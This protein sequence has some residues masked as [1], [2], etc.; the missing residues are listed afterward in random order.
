MKT[1]NR[2]KLRRLVEAGKVTAI[3][4]YSFDD[5]HGT[6]RGLDKEMAV[7]MMPD[8]RLKAREGTVHVWDSDFTGRGGSAREAGTDKHGRQVVVLRVH[9]NLNYTFAINDRYV[10]STDE[11]GTKLSNT[12]PAFQKAIADIA[13]LAR[14]DVLD[15]FALWLQYSDSDQSAILSEFVDWY[16]HRIDPEDRT[17]KDDYRPVLDEFYGNPA[18]TYID[19]NPNI[20]P[21]AA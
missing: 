11:L 1:F 3:D 14:R 6:E 13:S 21:I 17:T 19:R 10:I 9:S 2:L 4:A 18:L 5:Q 20:I 16:H 12:A 8:D 7:R 15:V